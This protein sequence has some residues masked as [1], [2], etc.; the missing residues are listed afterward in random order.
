MPSRLGPVNLRKSTHGIYISIS[1]VFILFII[2]TSIAAAEPTKNANKDERRF[3]CSPTCSPGFSCERKD[4][5]AHKCVLSKLVIAFIVVIAV[6]VFIVVPLGVTIICF[7]GCAVWRPERIKAMIKKTAEKR[8]NR[9]KNHHMKVI[10]TH[11]VN[12]ATSPA[13]TPPAATPTPSVVS[14]DNVF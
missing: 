11:D 1:V 10:S 6:L 2:G 5:H 7:T 9:K 3:G 4:G 12:N 14:G 13:T 8:R